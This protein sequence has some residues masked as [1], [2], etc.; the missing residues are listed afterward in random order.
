MDGTTLYL[1]EEIPKINEAPPVAENVTPSDIRPTLT[2]RPDPPATQAPPPEMGLEIE[3]SVLPPDSKVS[4]SDFPY[5]FM[6][7]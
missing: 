6:I 5:F 2:N 4:Y 3:S 1:D 7:W